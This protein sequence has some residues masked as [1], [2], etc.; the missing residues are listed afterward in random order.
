MTLDTTGCS[1][2]VGHA[3][4]RS[5]SEES[6]PSMTFTD[7]IAPYVRDHHATGSFNALSARRARNVLFAF[8]DHVGKRQV[9]NI[10][11]A[12]VESWLASIEH[13][14]PATRRVYLSTV[15]QMFVWT[16]RRGYCKRNPASE[17]RGPKQP[18]SIPRALPANSVA[19][20]LDSCPDARARLIIIL[21]CQQGLRCCEVSRLTLGDIDRINGTMRIVGKGDHERLLPVM[22]ETREALDDYLLEQPASAGPLVRSYRQPHRS[23]VPSTI[24][25][26]V[27]AWMYDAEVK[28]GPHDGV[29]AHAGRHTMATDLLKG[30]AHIRDVQAALGHRF[31]ATTEIYLPYLVN[32]LAVAMEGRTYRV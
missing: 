31:I 26:M 7:L 20:V 25:Q 17:I 14:S 28:R 23:L 12:H 8:A 21:M 13:L 22:V 1:N 11:A 29:G 18:R 9:R 10:G 15:R 5:S 2:C 27:A 32:G 16:I 4:D 19:K 30:G 3:D 6:G 24:S